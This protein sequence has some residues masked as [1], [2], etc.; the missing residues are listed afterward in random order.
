MKSH[1]LYDQTAQSFVNQRDVMPQG[2]LTD[3]IS[4][5]PS[6]KHQ[7]LPVVRTYATFAKC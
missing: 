3:L 4:C 1:I 2:K 6:K 7:P 5:M